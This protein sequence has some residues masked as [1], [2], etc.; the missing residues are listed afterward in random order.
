MNFKRLLLT[1]V[2]Q[3]LFSQTSHSRVCFRGQQPFELGDSFRINPISNWFLLSAPDEMRGQFGTWLCLGIHTGENRCK[4][5]ETN[6]RI[7]SIKLRE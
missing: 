1:V 5:L 4:V 2:S 7:C 3:S 6:F